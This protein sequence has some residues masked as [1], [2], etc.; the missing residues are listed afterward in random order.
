SDAAFLV[1]TSGTTGRPKGALHTQSGLIWNGINS[2]HYHDLTRGDHV[3]TV[4]P[5]FHV[6]GLCIQTLPALHAGATLTLHPRFDPGA[7]LADVASR[8]PTLTLVVP[9]VCRLWRM[10]RQRMRRG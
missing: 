4:L 8:R 10:A 5:M 2:T 9:A 3:L 1:Y 7:W 6:G